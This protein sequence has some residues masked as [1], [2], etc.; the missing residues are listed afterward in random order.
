MSFQTG[1][2]LTQLLHRDQVILLTL[3]CDMKPQIRF[4]LAF[5]QPYVGKYGKLKATV[6]Y[7]CPRNAHRAIRC[8]SRFPDIPVSSPGQQ[9]TI[10]NEYFCD[11][12]QCFEAY[13]IAGKCHKMGQDRFYT[14]MLL[15]IIYRILK[16][17]KNQ[18]Y[19]RITYRV[20]HHK[21]LCPP[22]VKIVRSLSLTALFSLCT[23]SVISAQLHVINFYPQFK[24]NSADIF[25]YQ[26][27]S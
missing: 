21:R 26:P 10:L 9:Q 1:V 3:T 25:Y 17:P 22:A 11:F 24:F 12:P 7:K 23:K 19:R 16:Q 13:P 4:C 6:T 27:I 5:W 14:Y 8:P 15:P 18:S 2:M 20:L